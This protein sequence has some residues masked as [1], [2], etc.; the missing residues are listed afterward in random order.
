[1]IARY[2]TL[3]TWLAFLSVVTQAISDAATLNVGFYGASETA[4]FGLDSDEEGFP[5]LSS[6]RCGLR[7]I[8]NAAVGIPIL[9][10]LPQP[11]SNAR[12]NIVFISP[13]DA[14]DLPETDR[15]DSWL[16]A[17]STEPTLILES[18]LAP[19]IGMSD[20]LILREQRDLYE[21]IGMAATKD[22][23]DEI[24]LEARG[25]Q[26]TLLQADGLHPNKRGHEFISSLIV[27]WLSSRHL[28]PP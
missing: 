19:E 8:I 16:R 17:L 11:Y 2:A 20:A 6:S 13:F 21:K 22:H 10:R 25:D 7:P 15:L 27:G 24:R 4:S 23:I 14:A 5:A 3:A 9:R 28:C 12:A 1:M 18:P 26:E